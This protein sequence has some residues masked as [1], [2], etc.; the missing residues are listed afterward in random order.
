MRPFFLTEM[1]CEITSGVGRMRVRVRA[2]WKQNAA[3]V[4]VSGTELQTH[5]DTYPW[6][7]PLEGADFLRMRNFALPRTPLDLLTREL[8]TSQR[9]VERQANEDQYPRC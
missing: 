7:T 5:F 1:V 9:N 4:D 8:R 6:F 2:R 3:T